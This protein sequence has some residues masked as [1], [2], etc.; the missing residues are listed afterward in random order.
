MSKTAI[1]PF[2]A[3]TIEPVTAA[4]RAQVVTASATDLPHVTSSLL[5]NVTT[6]GSISVL[7]PDDLDNNP[8]ALPFAVGTYQV[9]IQVRAVTAIAAGISV[10][11]LWS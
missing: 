6:A 5:I 7:F 9:N 1:D 4:R 8:V 2:F 11:A 10:V 3:S